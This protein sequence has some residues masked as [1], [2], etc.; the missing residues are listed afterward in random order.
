MDETKEVE[1]KEQEAEI[2]KEEAQEKAISPIAEVQPK[3]VEEPQTR[4]QKIGRRFKSTAFMR[5]MVWL[6]KR[7]MLAFWPTKVFFRE[8]FNI[9]G[10]AVVTCNHYGVFDSSTIIGNFYKKK[11]LAILLKKELM[12]KDN[13][14]SHFLDEIGGIPVNRHQADITAVK[15]ALKAL[16]NDQQLLIFPEGT[17][18]KKDTKEMGKIEEG[19]AMFA[20]KTKAPIVPLI[21]YR[22]TK[23]YKKNYLLVGNSFTLEEFYNDKSPDVKKKATQK[24][25]E[26]YAKLR[27]EID[28][29]V[30]V[31]HGSEKKYKKAHGI[32]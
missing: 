18:N 20:I 14:A 17:R 7:I 15:R 32:K 16:N 29:I 5:F 8:R 10:R 6:V 11:P 30:E 19:T 24:I 1:T 26:E 2:T 22:C 31:Y 12:E 4:A 23:W 13:F 27:A 9:T 28:E 25:V 21:Y 3:V